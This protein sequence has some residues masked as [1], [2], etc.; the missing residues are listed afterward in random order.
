MSSS[1]EKTLEFQC[2]QC[3]KRLRAGSSVAGK[4]LKCPG[5]G[6]PVKVPGAA[7]AAAEDDWLKLDDELTAPS[8]VPAP[9][10]PA[11][12]G[13]ASTSKPPATS[14]ASTK[15]DRQD[16]AALPKESPSSGL[17]KSSVFDDDLPE[18]AALEP[19]APK[20]NF[21]L[22]GFGD[23]SSLIPPVDLEAAA[24][25]TRSA[26]GGAVDL[27]IH[28]HAMDDDPASH[29]YRVPCP[30]CGTPHYAKI[31]DKGKTIK[32]PDC[33]AQFKVPGPPPG[34]KP[35]A[36]TRTKKWSTDVAPVEAGVE[37]RRREKEKVK[38]NEY[39]SKAQQEIS[40]DEIE[41]LYRDD[42]DTKGFFRKMFEFVFDPVA[43][44]QL[45]L[46][47]IAFAMIFSVSAACESKVAEGGTGIGYAFVSRLGMPLLFLLISFPMFSAVMTLLQSVAN[48]QSR[49]QSW[50]GFNFFDDMGEIFVCLAAF[51]AAVFPGLFCGWL[52]LK[53]GGVG[54]MVPVCVGLSL[55]LTFPIFLLSMLDNGSLFQPISGSVINSITA[56]SEA[57]GA[58]YLKTAFAFG[59]VE[60]IGFIVLPMGPGGSAVYGICMPWLIFFT[61]QQI[62]LVA[63]SISDQISFGS[64]PSTESEN[65]DESV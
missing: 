13:A 16:A 5:C 39:L 46:Y 20:A 56:A 42:F 49:V 32:C 19:E 63:T 54:W 36:T 2:P 24:T 29:E 40:D 58:Y 15:T 25:T 3:A 44:F 6:N 38:A 28:E 26:G 50:P 64:S 48:G 59:L 18:L 23:L 57:W 62:G 7:P 27:N 4:T 22:S 30:T 10:P 17:P 55:F 1:Q 9:P 34:W 31:A 37:E 43:L 11:R 51:L 52:I 47:S 33:Y 35:T 14:S 8:P 45:V 53:V 21:D 41:N 65:E 12:A 61:A 60:V